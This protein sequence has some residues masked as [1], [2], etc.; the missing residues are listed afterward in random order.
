VVVDLAIKDLPETIKEED[1]KKVSG[2]KHV[3]SATID[4]DKIRNVCTGTGRV[5]LRL[6][7]NEDVDSVKLKFI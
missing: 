4:E 6:A 5:K 2:A 1:L 7:A 3:I